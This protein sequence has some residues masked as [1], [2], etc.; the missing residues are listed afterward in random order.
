MTTLIPSNSH[1]IKTNS[2]QLVDIGQKRKQLYLAVSAVFCQLRRIY[3]A[4]L[5]NLTADEVHE[6]TAVWTDALSG[7]EIKILDEAVSRFIKT[8]KKGF[9]PVPGQIRMLAEEIETERKSMELER[10]LLG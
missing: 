8:D 9:C 4:Q 7:L 3:P 6:L 10:M 2:T 5:K 1:E